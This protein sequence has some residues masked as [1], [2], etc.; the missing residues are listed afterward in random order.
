MS[1]KLIHQQIPTKSGSCTTSLISNIVRTQLS[2][3]RITVLFS[4][5]ASNFELKP[6]NIFFKNSFSIEKQN[7]VLILKLQVVY[8]VVEHGI[9]EL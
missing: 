1:N 4:I 8:I 5:D 2:P 6:P 3:S 7:L 9:H